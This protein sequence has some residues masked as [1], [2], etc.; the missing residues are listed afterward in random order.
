MHRGLTPCLN[1]PMLSWL[2][3]YLA[4]CLAWLERRPSA[5]WPCK[6]RRLCW[7][8]HRTSRNS[9]RTDLSIICKSWVQP[10]SLYRSGTCLLSAEVYVMFTDP[11]TV[12][13]SESV[14]SCA[15]SRRKI[16]CIVGMLCA[17][18]LSGMGGFME[19]YVI[20][21]WIFVNASLR[22]LLRGQLR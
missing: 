18:P 17:V 14:R 13:G 2:R 21:R 11:G 19:V 6:M 8:P 9:W 16:Q 1:K 22:Y 3:A 10:S 4:A 12:V 15:G 5:P 20:L 7:L